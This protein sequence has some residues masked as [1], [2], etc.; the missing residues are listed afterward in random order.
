MVWAGTVV[1]E[2]LC[3]K[4]ADK[5]GTVVSES[6]LDAIGVLNVEFEVLRGEFV[7]NLYCGINSCGIIKLGI[8]NMCIYVLPFVTIA[9]PFASSAC[10]AMSAVGSFSSCLEISSSI[11]LMISS[12]LKVH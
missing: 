1:S 10:R 4:S 6:S 7:A 11:A 5:H 12:W 2:N 3:G 8:S 9:S